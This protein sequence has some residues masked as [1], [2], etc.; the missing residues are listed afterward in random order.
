[1]AARRSS[2]QRRKRGRGDGLVWKLL[3]P[4]ALR[5][6]V[7][8]VAILVLRP[9]SNPTAIPTK[10]ACPQV[11]DVVIGAI[12]VPSGPIEGYCQAALVNAAQ[13]IAAS[14]RYTES[15]H[16]MDIGVMVAIGESNLQ[17]LTYGDAAGP[18]SRGIFQQRANWGTLAQR[19]D[20]FTAA[21]DFYHRMFGVVGWDTLPPTQVAHIVQGNA[22][23]DYYTP[24]FPKAQ[25]IVAALL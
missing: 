23:L 13:I 17:N 6:A 12:S 25:S 2:S 19:M 5:G 24:Y 20:P 11:A 9:S 10:P 4:A 7:V 3:V 22:N 21:Y 16:A 8:V 18:D 14:R 1:M 15:E